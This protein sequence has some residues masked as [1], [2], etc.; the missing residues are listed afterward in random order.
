MSLG[1]YSVLK[2]YK[3]SPNEVANFL[4]EILRELAEPLCPND[5][6]ENFRDIPKTFTP[7]QK[8]EKIVDLMFGL[9]ELNRHTLLYLARFF[10]RIVSYQEFNKM[11]SYNIAVILSPNIFRVK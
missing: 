5:K 9:P 10:N 8:L 11:N 2:D 7:E 1:D 4:K 6:Y 3:D